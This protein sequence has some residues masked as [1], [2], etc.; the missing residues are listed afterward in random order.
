MRGGVRNSLRRVSGLSRRAEHF[1]GAT[2]L[3]FSPKTKVSTRRPTGSISSGFV[4]AGDT[5]LGLIAYPIEDRIWVA[6]MEQTE[7]EM[8]LS[9][10]C[11]FGV[12]GYSILNTIVTYHTHA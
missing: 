7:G 6:R 1:W 3:D 5:G 9:Y 10:S 12:D 8:R 11:F 2:T 4:Q